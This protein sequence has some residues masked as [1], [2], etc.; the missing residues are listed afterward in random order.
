M[1]DKELIQKAI[2]ANGGEASYNAVFE[3]ISANAPERTCNPRWKACIYRV[4]CKSG[5]FVVATRPEGYK[6]LQ[7]MPVIKISGDFLLY[8]PLKRQ[9]LDMIKD[10]RKTEEYREIGTYW[11]LRIKNAIEAMNSGRMVVARFHSYRGD[12]YD[13]QIDEILQGIGDPEIGAPVNQQVWIL[14]LASK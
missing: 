11:N 2:E 3:W 1:K 10:G 9:W 4:A 12:Y 7:K 8:L 14:K 5:Q 6:V 13:R